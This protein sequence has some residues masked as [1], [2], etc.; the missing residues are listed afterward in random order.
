MQLYRTFS[1]ADSPSVVEAMETMLPEKPGIIFYNCL[2]LHKRY[3]PPS[4]SVTISDRRDELHGM[5]DRMGQLIAA[6]IGT[7]S[8]TVNQ[9]TNTVNQA[10]SGAVE[11]L[12]DALLPPTQ[13]PAHSLPLPP[14]PL[15]LPTP[16]EPSQRSES[17]LEQ[18]PV[19][20]Y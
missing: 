17:E 8:N 7:L 10:I 13:P 4:C 12:R 11:K 18:R 15:Q 14:S 2:G 6:A 20:I 5:E 19:C 16:R 1:N 3:C 9:A